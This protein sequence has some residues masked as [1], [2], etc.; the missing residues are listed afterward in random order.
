MAKVVARTEFSA[1]V[2]QLAKERGIDPEIV[3]ASIEAAIVAAYKKDAKENGVEID[4]E[5][6]DFRVS[7]DPV[8]GGVRVVE[9]EIEN[10]DGEGKD[11]TPPGFGRIAAQTAK[12]VIMQ[13]MREAEKSALI[14]VYRDRV[15][16]VMNGMVL[17]YD[18]P[19][20]VVDLGKAE[21][22]M[23]PHEQVHNEN[24]DLNKRMAFYIEGIRE[25][26]KGEQII[27]SRSHAQLV[28]QLF[29]REVP[30]VNSGSVE[31]KAIAREAGA[32]TK[33]AVDSTQQGVDPVGSCVGQKG[34][35][36][37]S[38]INELNG[39]KIDIIEYDEDPVR[40][41]AAAISPATAE[42]VKVNEADESALIIVPD[43]QLSLA[44]GKDGQN[45]RL[46][47]KLT[48]Y[49][50]DVEG[51]SGI[52][53][54]S[55]PASMEVAV[56]ENDTVMTEESDEVEVAVE[57]SVE[58]ADQSVE[59]AEAVVELKETEESTETEAV[60]EQVIE[61]VAEEDKKGEK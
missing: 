2:S 21:A 27:V 18:G 57:E 34:V 61:K 35:R 38:V 51:A 4:E 25:T 55:A 39:E 20:V 36:V 41:I 7:V 32:R 9:F 46:A 52:K 3:L 49:K 19:F 56:S 40:F 22:L 58:S 54:D 5:V 16:N 11:V 50:L 53:P 60:K 45:V 43:D 48:G 44:I 14:A 30:E 24:Y 42:S 47:A 29:A 37:Q 59:N 31:I 28:S 15:G 8:S 26:M 23:P 33:I 13:K 17:R 1:A 12:Q 6:V 10:S